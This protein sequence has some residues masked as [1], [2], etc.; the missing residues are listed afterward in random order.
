MAKLI[1]VIDVT[2][3]T[4]CRG[5]QVACKNW[6]QN[7]AV[8][9]PFT[10]SYQTHKDTNAETY[11]IV[12]FNEY[13]DPAKGVRWLFRKHQCMHCDNPACMEACP[14]QAYS[15]TEWGATLHD[16]NRCIGC[17]YC[18]YACP[19]SVPKYL[20][21]EDV[22]TKCTLC[23]NRVEAGLKPACV[24]TCPS[25]AL[26]FGDQGELMA[27]AQERVSFLRNNGFP[28]ATLYGVNEM[29]GCNVVYVLAYSPDKYGLPVN[30]KV[31]GQVSFWQNIVQPYAGWLI[32]LALGA[33]VVSFFTTRLIAA[34]ERAPEEG[35]NE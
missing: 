25:G 4:A 34:S 20:K 28:E 18:H 30:P 11:T 3:C 17:Q 35:G 26:Q 2:K 31:S 10:G 22:V 16:I 19:W 32:P 21:R 33:S 9:E 1:K 14:R 24:Q 12:K 13:V 6:N 29:G 7:P 5:C 15:K 23:A 27:Y 8:I